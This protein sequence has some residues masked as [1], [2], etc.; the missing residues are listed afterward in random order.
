MDTE[1]ESSVRSI[2][3]NFG[4]NFSIKTGIDPM[5]YL[6]TFHGVR[7]HLTMYGLP[8]DSL[9][10]EIRRAASGKDLTIIV[11]SSKVP[12][13]YYEKSDF[14]V[15]ITNQPISEVSALAIFL[16]RFFSGSE[17]QR[18]MLGK[19]NVQ[20]TPR[21]KMIT[22]VPSEAKCLDILRENGA[23]QRIVDH[24]RAVSKLA[25]AIAV[26]AGAD[27]ELVQAGALLHDIGR[28][29]TN[30]IYHALVGAR[31]LR[32]MNIDQRVVRIVERH[33]GAG[34]PRKEAVSLGLGNVDYI[35][36]TLEEK[37]VAQADN[38]I[39]GIKRVKLSDVIESYKRKG[40]D[41]AALRISALQTELSGLC[42]TDLD[43]IS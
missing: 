13:E 18:D 2:T 40:L 7:V 33:T 39:S 17:L 20:P 11:G 41:E 38:L 28:T 31:M 16:D 43:S 6:K 30:G 27:K 21:G 3:S 22:I 4:G 35:P 42:G 1:L 32:E 8:V 34:I 24:C 23:D 29:S 36:E 10:E 19:V 12:F 5:E 25:I 26:A 37:I 14:N 9:M 15:S